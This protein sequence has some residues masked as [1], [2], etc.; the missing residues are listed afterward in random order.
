MGL[1]G[2][3]S[4]A[5]INR[6]RQLKL[7]LRRSPDADEI[8][9]RADRT[10]VDATDPRLA[11]VAGAPADGYSHTG[12]LASTAADAKRLNVGLLACLIACLDFWS[13]IALGVTRLQ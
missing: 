4:A 7:L 2:D 5:A 1:F 12:R 8:D 3:F 9:P 6:A 13:L 11:P 10:M